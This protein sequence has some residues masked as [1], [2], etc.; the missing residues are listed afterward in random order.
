MWTALLS[1]VALLPTYTKEGNA[2]VPF[3]VG[4]LALAL[5]V[6]FHPG[7]RSAREQSGRTHHPTAHGG[8]D[9]VDLETRR[10]RR[11]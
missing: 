11:A 6:W 1:G 9:V 4:A 2:L 8:D 10:R 7:V 3:G 5:F